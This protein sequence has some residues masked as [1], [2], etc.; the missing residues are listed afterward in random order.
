[1][2]SKG[3]KFKQRPKEEKKRIMLRVKNGENSINQIARE[4][5]IN[6]GMLA[7][8]LKK[9]NEFGEESLE[10]KYKLRIPK[11]RKNMTEYE[12]LQLENLKLRIEN[13]RLKKGYIVKGVGQSK[14]YYSIVKKNSQ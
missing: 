6:S 1:M 4:E 10:R 7:N 2:A 11:K 9:Y 3:Q 5:Q 8:W 12:K 14:K 13:E